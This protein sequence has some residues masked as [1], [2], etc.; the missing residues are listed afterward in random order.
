[1][2][3][4]QEK[5][6]VLTSLNHG[7]RSSYSCETQ[8]V[9]TIHDM[10]QSFDKGKQIDI[11]ILDLSK[12]FDTVPHDRLLHSLKSSTQSPMTDSSIK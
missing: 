3:K 2:M 1:M 4:H 7:F 9:V 11:G 12:A 6:N 8:L 5:H 10:L